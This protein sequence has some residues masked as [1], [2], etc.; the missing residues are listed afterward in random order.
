L[1]QQKNAHEI[2]ASRFV[3]QAGRHQRH[4]CYQP[5]S[6]CEAPREDLVVA[7]WQQK[8]RA[9]EFWCGSDESHEILV[10]PGNAVSK[11]ADRCCVTRDP[12]VALDDR[13]G[14][15]I[16]CVFQF[17]AAI[18]AMYVE[19]RGTSKHA[20]LQASRSESSAART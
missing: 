5:Q 15:F 7:R 10:V 14:L 4:W 9:G 16:D 3:V 17:A 2:G 20:A 18:E 8:P 13:C 19:A 6:V 11:G 12:T 1:D